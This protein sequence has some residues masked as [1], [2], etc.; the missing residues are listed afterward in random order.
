[1]LKKRLIPVLLLKNSRMVKGRQFHDYRDTGDPVSA[2]KIYNAQKADE[3]M[4]LDIDASRDGRSTLLQVVEK[5]SK[6][7][8]MPFTVGGGI[9]TVEDI[10][11][12]LH[13]GADKILINS[14]AVND[15]S[16]VQRAA[17]IF[18]RQCI[19]CGVDV[20]KENE[21]YRIYTYCGSKPTDLHLAQHIQKMEAM[22][23]GEF[24]I[25]SIDRDGMM[26]GY[27]GDLLKMVVS[28]T[29]RPVVACGGAGNFKH[30]FDAFDLYGVHAVACASLF[31]F[32]DNNPIRAR[33]YL[34]NK[35]ILVKN[36]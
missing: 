1:M 8:F 33:A 5:V 35:G 25:N 27:D 21:K 26:N 24:M 22:G 29:K 12:L 20:R 3:L 7:C 34:K 28:M 18:G 30:L 13:A 32:G 10:R 17:N 4:F 16:F 36:V 2:A 15:P 19:V 9:R 6:E 31:H 11:D 14:A 23:T